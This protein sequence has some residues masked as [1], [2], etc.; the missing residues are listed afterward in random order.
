MQYL[1]RPHHPEFKEQS[2]AVERNHDPSPVRHHRPHATSALH[3]S[4]LPQGI[5]RGQTG[6]G[7]VDTVHI[8][9]PRAVC[10]FVKD[11]L[12]LSHRHIGAVG[13]I[14]SE[15]GAVAVLSGNLDALRLREVIGSDWGKGHAI[16]FVGNVA[17]GANF[18]AEEV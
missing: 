12:T 7:L 11:D 8:G 5:G 4:R 14:D 16:E 10:V 1:R 15:K 3:V 9:G 13:T 17:E 18:E 6:L 2:A